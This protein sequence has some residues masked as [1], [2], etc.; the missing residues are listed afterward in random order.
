MREK[1]KLKPDTSPRPPLEP[2][3]ARDHAAGNLD[4]AAGPAE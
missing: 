3:T 4:Y 2:I 1:T